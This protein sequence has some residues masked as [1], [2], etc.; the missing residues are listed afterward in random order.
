M[1]RNYVL[2]W[3]IKHHLKGDRE[4][5]YVAYLDDKKQYLDDQKYFGVV[6]GPYSTEVV[7]ALIDGE[8]A[9]S[10]RTDLKDKTKVKHLHLRL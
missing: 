2:C 3:F 1:T 9:R 6:V 4:T 7:F 8:F 5:A 10:P